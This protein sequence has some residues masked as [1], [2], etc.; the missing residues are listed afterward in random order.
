MTAL[1][2]RV[3]CMVRQTWGSGARIKMHW[4][5][6]PSLVDMLEK[7]GYVSLDDTVFLFKD[8]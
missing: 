5:C 2:D 8:F 3:E 1:L 4:V 7:R 6:N